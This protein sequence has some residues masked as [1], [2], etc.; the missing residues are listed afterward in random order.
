MSESKFAKPVYIAMWSGPRNISTAMMRSWENRPD[1]Q[2][3]DEP[4]YSFYLDQTGLDHPMAAEIID[5]YPCDAATVIAE[6]TAPLTDTTVFYQKHMTHHMLP[7]VPLGW[8][9]QMVNCFLIRDPREVITSYIKVRPNVTLEDI[10]FKQQIDIFHHV[11]HHVDH[12]PAVIDSRDV[13]ENPELI[14]GLLCDK[15]GI[16]FLPEMLSWPA[17]P[18]ESDGIWAQH[19]YS[20]VEKSTAFA[21]YKP[22]SDPLPDHLRPMLAEC[23]RYYE[24]MAQFKLG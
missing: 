22:K 3:V 6:L 1:T 10:G 13:L 20:T 8:L 7:N 5:A 14:L 15:I 19:W 9:D 11:R 4:F 18:R 12:Q 17:G 24:E 23:E 21:P 2:V 16:P